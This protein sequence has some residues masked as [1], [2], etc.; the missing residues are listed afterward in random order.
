MLSSLCYTYVY[1]HIN[2]TVCVWGWIEKE[3]LGWWNNNSN[4]NVPSIPF[5]C[6]RRGKACY[7][8]PDIDICIYSKGLERPQWW[9][10]II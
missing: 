8:L 4:C 10:T 7:S 6:Q 3:G 5:L 9:P 2:M 1:I